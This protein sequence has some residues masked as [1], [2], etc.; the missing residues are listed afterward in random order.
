MNLSIARPL[1]FAAAGLLISLPLHAQVPSATEMNAQLARL[2]GSMQAAAEACGGYSSEALAEHKQQQK[3]HLAQA[4]M[5]SVSFEKQFIAGAHELS[6]RF[7]S[8]PDAERQASCEEFR[9]H[10]SA[11]R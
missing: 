5:D 3:D 11:M 10:L 1:T 2:G 6:T 8:M 9:Q 7:R 4:G